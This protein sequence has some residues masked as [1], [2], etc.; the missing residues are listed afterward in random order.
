MDAVLTLTPM[1]QAPHPQRLI[2]ADD[3]DARCLDEWKE[4]RAAQRQGLQLA[5]DLADGFKT[6]ETLSRMPATA[7]CEALLAVDI[8]GRLWHERAYPV[9]SW[10]AAQALLDGQASASSQRFKIPVTWVAAIGGGDEKGGQSVGWAI[11]NRLVRQLWGNSAS[12]TTLPLNDPDW[13]IDDTSVSIWLPHMASQHARAL[14]EH[15]SSS[16]SDVLRNTLYLHLWGRL[17]YA[18]ATAEGSWRATRRGVEDIEIRYSARRAGD[19]SDDLDVPGPES[20]V[21]GSPAHQQ[22]SL[23]RDASVP[24]RTERVEAYGKSADAVKVWLPTPM[25]AKLAQAA[26]QSQLRLSDHCR[27]VIL[28]MLYGHRTPTAS[29]P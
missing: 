4:S 24:R 26:A 5:P 23:D 9:S 10:L 14:A 11:R 28:A 25:K 8:R 29:K 22:P 18:E 16:L 27:D 17:G 6:L 20:D 21:D 2:L 19:I 1:A 7:W 15:F 13:A 12:P 3:D